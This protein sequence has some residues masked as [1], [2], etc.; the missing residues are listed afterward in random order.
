MYFK[1]RLY[2]VPAIC[3]CDQRPAVDLSIVSYQNAGSFAVLRGF[4][5][6]EDF[7][8]APDDAQGHAGHFCY[9]DTIAAPERPRRHAMPENDLALF[10]LADGHRILVRVGQ[11]LRHQSLFVVVSG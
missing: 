4:E 1:L 2:S 5:A 10:I 8:G 11:V 7:S 6:F 3:I 9:M